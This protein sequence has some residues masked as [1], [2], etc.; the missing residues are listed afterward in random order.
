MQGCIFFFFLGKKASAYHRQAYL[1]GE[2]NDYWILNAPSLENFN[3]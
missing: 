3:L 1:G 2:M